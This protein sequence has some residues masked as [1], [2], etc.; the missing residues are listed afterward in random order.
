M[1]TCAHFSIG[2][3]GFFAVDLCESFETIFSHCVGCVFFFLFFFSFFPFFFF[4]F[5]FFVFFFFLSF[6]FFFFFFFNGFF[7]V[8]KLLSLIRSHWFLFV[9]ISIALGDWPKKIFVR[10]MSEYV[11]LCSLLGVLWCLMFKTKPF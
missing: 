7:A 10:L 9:F 8:Q 6:F 5:F 1:G 3:F 4:F 11:C 2:L